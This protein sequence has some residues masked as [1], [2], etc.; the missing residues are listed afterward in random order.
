MNTDY[1]GNNSMSKKYIREMSWGG[2]NCKYSYNN[3]Y[4]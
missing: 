4:E 1:I 3:T 2:S